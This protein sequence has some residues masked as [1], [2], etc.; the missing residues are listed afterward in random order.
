MDTLMVVWALSVKLST[1]SN[2]SFTARISI[3][4]S[5]RLPSPKKRKKEE[6][7]IESL[8]LHWM[9]FNACII[10][11]CNSGKTK[12][13]P[14]YQNCRIDEEYFQASRNPLTLFFLSF[15]TEFFQPWRTHLSFPSF[16]TGFVQN[17][18]T[19]SIF[20]YFF[21]SS[22]NLFNSWRTYSSFPPFFTGFFQKERRATQGFFLS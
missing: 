3:K 17:E 5:W 15:S 20:L 2:I 19:H 4:H 6:T 22:P 18:R 21:L 1:F 14:T 11:T 16:F 9:C 10:S 7:H 8:K 13:N 12:I